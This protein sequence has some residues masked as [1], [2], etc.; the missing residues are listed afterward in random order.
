MARSS[1]P[2]GP[3]QA[4]KGEE[5]APGVITIC[6]S[7]RQAADVSRGGPDWKRVKEQRLGKGSL[8]FL[9]DCILIFLTEAQ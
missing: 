9:L 1:L 6:M 4:G 8:I 7:R 5:A 3:V 2:S